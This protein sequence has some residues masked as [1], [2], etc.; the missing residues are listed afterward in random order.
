MSRRSEPGEHVGAGV[1][2]VGDAVRA[3][4]A[5]GEQDVQAAAGAE[6]QHGLAWLDVGHRERVAAAQAGAQRHPLGVGGVGVGGRAEQPPVSKHGRDRN[7]SGCRRPLRCGPGLNSVHDGIGLL[8]APGAPASVTGLLPLSMVPGGE[9]GW[10]ARC[11]ITMSAAVGKQSTQ[12]SL[13]R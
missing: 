12:A 5:R 1:Q 13:I 9:L 6:V 10:A 3:D 7:R 4:S 2:A 11:P 8:R